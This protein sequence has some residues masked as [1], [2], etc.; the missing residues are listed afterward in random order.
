MLLSL[1]MASSIASPHPYISSP[2]LSPRVL[3]SDSIMATRN[4]SLQRDPIVC[5]AL[6]ISVNR[7]CEN[8]LGPQWS[9]SHSEVRFGPGADLLRHEAQRQQALVMLYR[10]YRP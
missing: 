2:E 4:T 3:E 7:D 5:P 1:L 6:E 9:A 8:I 10:S